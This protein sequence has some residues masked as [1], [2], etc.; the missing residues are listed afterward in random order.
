MIPTHGRT[1][2]YGVVYIQVTGPLSEPAT[3]C[4]VDYEMRGKHYTT[5]GGCNFMLKTHPQ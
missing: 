3:G 5:I 2:F 1:T 4:S